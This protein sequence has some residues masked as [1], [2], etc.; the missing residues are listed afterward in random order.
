[1]NIGSNEAILRL[2]VR[3][4][5]QQIIIIINS[6]G[7]YYSRKVHAHTTHTTKT[8]ILHAIYVKWRNTGWKIVEDS[9]FSRSQQRI[10]QK[11][12]KCSL[13]KWAN[14][15]CTATVRKSAFSQERNV[16]NTRAF[17]LRLTLHRTATRPQFNKPIKSI[18]PMQKMLKMLSPPLSVGRWPLARRCGHRV[19][20]ESMPKQIPKEKVERF[21]NGRH[22]L[23]QLIGTLF[24]L[25]TLRR[26]ECVWCAPLG[27]EIKSISVSFMSKIQLN[28]RNVVI[29][30]LHEKRGP[31]FSSLI[32]LK[33]NILFVRF[34]TPS[35]AATV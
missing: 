12:A 15:S 8:A 18:E 32:D 1:M 25:C 23:C 14:T 35:G 21:P 24:V 6:Y 28:V 2:T 19:P 13:G 3:Q 29:W 17:G 22:S 9:I 20:S 5:H 16:D 7:E 26:W 30:L 33:L 27:H 4:Q 11:T 34:G 10:S 31:H